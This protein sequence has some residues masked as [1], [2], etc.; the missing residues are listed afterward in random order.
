MTSP[1]S[2]LRRSLSNNSEMNEIYEA[3]EWYTSMDPGGGQPYVQ[4]GPMS[5]GQMA[6]T[7]PAQWQ[8]NLWVWREKSRHDWT[9][10]ADIIGWL[11]R[12]FQRYADVLDGVR[13]GVNDPEKEAVIAEELRMARL[14]P[15]AQRMIHACHKGELEVLKALEAEWGKPPNTPLDTEGHCRIHYAPHGWKP[16]NVA[17]LEYLLDSGANIDDTDSFGDTPLHHAAF[18]GHRRIVE[19]LLSKGADPTIRNLN[20]ATPLAVAITKEEH[21]GA[22]EPYENFHSYTECKRMLTEAITQRLQAAA[23]ADT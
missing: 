6:D 19:F 14:D 10:L 1:T 18:D 16:G 22:T 5:L 3:V 13:D 2:E 20:G 11:P 23:E 7:L 8:D 21:Y 17:V 12:S 4:K 15:I 9:K